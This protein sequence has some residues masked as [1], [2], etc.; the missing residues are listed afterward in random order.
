ML[1]PNLKNG[2]L[3]NIRGSSSPN[4]ALWLKTGN[5][6]GLVANDNGN[7]SIESM[8]VHAGAYLAHQLTFPGF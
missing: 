4:I 2:L 8:T 1:M 3:P 7:L 6:R 5:V